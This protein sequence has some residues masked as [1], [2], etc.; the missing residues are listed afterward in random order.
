M[1]KRCVREKADH[2][3]DIEKLILSLQ[4]LINIKEGRFKIELHNGK[5]KTSF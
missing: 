3:K 2:L 5:R 4:K 1:C